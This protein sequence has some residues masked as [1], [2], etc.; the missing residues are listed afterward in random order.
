MSALE[1]RYRRNFIVAVVLHIGIIGGIVLLEQLPSFGNRTETPL[2]FVEADILGELPE[3]AGTGRGAYKA[4]EPES[5]KAQ[6][7]APANSSSDDTVA[8]EPKRSPVPKADPN[9][10]AIPTKKPTP[11]K[12]SVVATAAKPVATKKPAAAVSNSAAQTGGTSSSAA[13]IK[14][15][16][17]SALASSADGTAGGD[18]KPAGGGKGKGSRIGSPGGSPD[19]VAGGVGQGTP[20]WQYFRQVHDALYQ[21]WEQPDSAVDKKL[22]TTVA[23]R[24][25]RDGSIAD[26]SVRLGS[27]NKSM[28]ESVLSAVRRVPRLDPPPDALVRGEYAVITVN[29]QAEG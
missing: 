24:V 5:I 18:N 14:R 8:P 20:N 21:A 10:I 23:L 1:K 12:T 25:A 15:R 3:G 29:F 28:D 17:A 13:D 27:G 26:A 9:E 11:K 22:M 4:P 19:G 6:L 16:F 2:A 7:P